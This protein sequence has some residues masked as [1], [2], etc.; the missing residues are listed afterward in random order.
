MGATGPE[1]VRVDGVDPGFGALL[2]EPRRAWP[3]E[4]ASFTPWLEDHIGEFGE[5]LGLDLEVESRE[6]PVGAF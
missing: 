6:A 3:N 1:R 5:V 2:G 4:A